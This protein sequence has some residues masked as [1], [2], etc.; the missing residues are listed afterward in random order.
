MKD[1]RLDKQ[2]S[3][4]EEAIRPNELKKRQREFVDWDRNFLLDRQDRFVAVDCPACNSK[5]HVLHFEKD[6]MKYHLCHVCETLFVN[7]RPCIELLHE[8][9]IKSRNYDYWN[10][11]IFPASED[12]RRNKIFKPRVL[13]TIE[14][15]NRFLGE[16]QTI[17]EVGAGFG[18]FSEEAK[19]TGRFKNVIAIE[20]TPGLAETCRKRGLHTIELPIENLSA[21]IMTDIIVTFE[22]I[23]HLFSVDAFLHSCVNHL[24]D[25]GLLIVSCPN[26]QGFDNQILGAKSETIDHEHLN[27]FNPASLR[28]LFERCGLETLEIHTPGQLDADIVRNAALRGDICLDNHPFL[29]TVLLDRWDEIGDM[30]QQFLADNLLSGHMWIAAQKKNVS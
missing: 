7:P 3:F 8:F 18:I 1:D 17:M 20:P 21:D 4:S 24:E 16:Y 19:K 14:L 22:V 12:V 29:K 11:Y 9:Y 2:G 30:F 26:F 28:I 23:E 10:S 27:Y 13:R 6:G 25:L 15:A 5:N